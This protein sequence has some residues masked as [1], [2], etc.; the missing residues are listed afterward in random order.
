MPRA[1]W[2]G[3][4]SF[5]LVNVP[6]RLFSAVQQHDVQSTWCTPRTAAIGYEKYC[7]KERKKVPADEIVK[8]YEMKGGKLVY[9]ED[10][11]FEAAQTKG[12]TRSS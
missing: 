6:V 4:I 7:K 10:S 5:G 12:S 9:L 3:A 2:S 1:I 8:A 11:D